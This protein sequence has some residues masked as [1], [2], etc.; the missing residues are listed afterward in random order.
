MI[1][2]LI[3]TILLQF[4][5]DFGINIINHPVSLISSEHMARIVP[6]LNDPYRGQRMADAVCIT[7]TNNIYLNA[8]HWKDLNF[9]QKRELLY[10]ELGHCVLGLSHNPDRSIMNPFTKNVYH[11]DSRGF[12]WPWLVSELKHRYCTE[13]KK[14]GI[15][16][17]KRF[18]FYR[19]IPI[20]DIDMRLKF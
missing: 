18:K 4:S 12:N 5:S 20:R 13:S 6:P 11:T 15:F 19:T 3:L 14:V 16:S 10:H 1:N 17:C 8:D 9:F 2:T 7:N